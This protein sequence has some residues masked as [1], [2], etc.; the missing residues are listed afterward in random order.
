MNDFSKLMLSDE[1]Q[2]LVNNSRWILTKRVI[3][4][5]ANALLGEL[6]E[7]QKAVIQQKKD[8]L[9][10]AVVQSDAKISKGENYQQLP[11]LILDYPRCFDA[12][13]IFAIRTMFWWGN[14]F[15]V[16]LH[17]AGAHKE[18]YE[19]V[20]I[21]RIDKLKQGSYYL[22]VHESQWHHHFEDDNYINTNQLNNKEA[23]DIIRQ[24]Q[25][26]KLS[27]KFPLQQWKEMPLLLEKSF[28]GIIELLKD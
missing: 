20:L 24:K 11:F 12:K 7:K 19:Q 5:K 1:E 16:T 22:C 28:T 23:E 18:N 2:Q 13:N 10:A 14:F 26:I 17:L 21:D 9:P 27:V 3:I 8:F 25:F 15:S 4:G 6:S